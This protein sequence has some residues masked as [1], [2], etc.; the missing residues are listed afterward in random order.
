MKPFKFKLLLCLYLSIF[1]ISNSS[2]EEFTLAIEDSWPPYATSD[3]YGYSRIIVEEAYK[4]EG[5]EPIF[6]PMPY[7]RAL[8]LTKQGVTNGC[9]NVTRQKST[10][11][12]YLFGE[13]PLFIAKASLYTTKNQSKNF[14]SLK[15]LP[16]KFKLG[17]IKGYEYG[18]I[19]EK[20]KERFE[21]LGVNSQAQLIQ[22]LQ[23]KRIDGAIMFNGVARYH[24]KL[25]GVNA[26]TFIP[27]FTN[28]ISHIYVAFNKKD[29]LS[30][31]YA[32]KLDDGLKKLKNSPRYIEIFSSGL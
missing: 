12:A 11:A 18:D 2:A 28:H 27:V 19:F 5:I 17:V 15:D 24:F 7:A 31:M 4:L 1:H 25:M 10:E 26:T 3:G 6:A 14:E 29:T 9:F 23:K 21:I 30:A 8:L 13:E 22:L 16:D 20:E 32:K